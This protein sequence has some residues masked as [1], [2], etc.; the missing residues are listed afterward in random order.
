MAE[1]AVPLGE[2]GVVAAR[3]SGI[4]R[5]PLTGTVAGSSV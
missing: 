2:A 5:A 4:V 3:V 1:T